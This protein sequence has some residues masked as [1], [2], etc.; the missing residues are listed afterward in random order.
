MMGET[1][2]HHMGMKKQ[3]E[4]S[5]KTT[6]VRL[7]QFSM[8]ILDYAGAICF[9]YNKSCSSFSMVVLCL[10]YGE[11]MQKK[12]GVSMIIIYR[13]RVWCVIMQSCKVYDS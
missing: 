7:M 9:Y 6:Q 8:L 10:Q 5:T 3:R 11:I 12:I 2:E 13:D 4:W 1:Q